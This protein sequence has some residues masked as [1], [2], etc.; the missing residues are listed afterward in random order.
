MNHRN[1]PAMPDSGVQVVALKCHRLR[2]ADSHRT[3]MARPPRVGHIDQF[4][5][6]KSVGHRGYVPRNSDAGGK[7]NRVVMAGQD[8][9][10]GAP[11]VDQEQAVFASSDVRDTPLNR[12]LP[13]MTEAGQLTL[14]PRCVG[15]S[16]VEDE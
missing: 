2:L 8:R 15:L 16:E 7:F 1:F 4:H 13:Y 14:D 9:L 6:G 10:I 3:E 12:N 5:A 11:H